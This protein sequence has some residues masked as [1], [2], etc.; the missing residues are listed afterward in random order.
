[1]DA[2]QVHNEDVNVSSLAHVGDVSYRMSDL[3]SWCATES[4]KENWIQLTF[5]S[6]HHVRAFSLGGNTNTSTVSFPKKFR[7]FAKLYPWKKWTPVT[8]NK[9]G[10]VVGSL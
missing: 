6:I 3:E 7:V 4:D 2:I 5:S 10:N 9:T 1:M 8:I